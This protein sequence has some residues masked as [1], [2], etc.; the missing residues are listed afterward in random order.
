MEWELAAALERVGEPEP[1]AVQE[2][3]AVRELAA[4][5]AEAFPLRT[6]PAPIT[7]TARAIVVTPI[8][9]VRAASISSAM[10]LV[11]AATKA[12]VALAATPANPRVIAA[13]ILATA[14]APRTAVANPTATFPAPAATKR[15]PV[16]VVGTVT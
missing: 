3:A 8:T 6:R 13:M 9:P 14:E 7:V 4:V 15:A 10:R 16:A 11:I 5:R 1:A 12:A 2:P